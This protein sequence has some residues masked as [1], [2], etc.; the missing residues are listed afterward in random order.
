MPELSIEELTGF[1]IRLGDDHHHPYD[2]ADISWNESWF[3][4][5]FAPDGT[6]AGHCRIGHMPNQERVW[7]WLYLFDTAVVPGGEWVCIEQPWLDHN[8]LQVPTLAYD[9]LGLQFRHEPLHPMASGRLTLHGPARIV[10]GPRAS[11]VTTIDVEVAWAATGGPHSPG[12]GD[13]RGH[14]SDGFDASRMEQPFDATVRHAIGSHEVTYAARGERDHSWGP[15]FWNMDWTFLALSSSTR[16]TQFVEVGIKGLDPILLGYLSTGSATSALGAVEIDLTDHD[17]LAM[18][19]SGR[20]A[21]HA[22]G[23]HSVEGNRI[24]HS[25][26]GSIEVL[27]WCGLDVS[28]VLTPP[29]S[30]DY[31]RSLIRLTPDDGGEP[32]MGWLETNRLLDGDPDKPESPLRSAMPDE[33]GAAATAAMGDAPPVPRNEDASD[34]DL[35]ALSAWL[36]TQFGAPVTIAEASRPEG[37]GHSNETWLVTAHVD[38]SHDRHLVVRLQPTGVGV[39]PEYRLDHQVRCM[40]ALGTTT[41]PAPIVTGFEP[42]IGPLGR[43]FYVMERIDGVV[44]PDYPPYTL[45]GWFLEAAEADQAAVYASSLAT[46]AALHAFD[47]FEHGFGFLVPDG[48]RTEQDCLDHQ[49]GYWRLYLDHFLADLAPLPVLTPGLDWLAAN[50]PVSERP[51]RL[52]WGDARISNMIFRDNTPA[53]VIDWEMASL[54]APEVDLAWYTWLEHFFAEGIGFPYLPGYPGEAAAIALYEAAA[55]RTVEAF[56]WHTVFAGVRYAA[57]LARIAAMRIA[58][59]ELSPEDGQRAARN[60]PNTRRLAGLLD[61]PSPGEPGGPFG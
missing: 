60:N 21:V 40:Q 13:V 30:S 53:A 8:W 51:A 20:V 44:P 43:P 15:R 9:R 56:D 16:R 33:D 31:R 36:S 18:P 47:P 39:F 19:F 35:R 54:G 45:A 7:L 29:R 3:W 46:L 42:D 59:G 58:T 6:F 11:T 17:D 37:A 49:L 1:G 25:I 34:T 28:H 52:N 27:T 32:L 50:R 38:N 5:W 48:L 14:A 12:Q 57:V 23:S 26:A 61:L 10:T 4:D 2:P 22:T 24:G 41:I 55:G